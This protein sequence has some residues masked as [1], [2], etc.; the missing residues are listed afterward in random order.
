[1]PEPLR[2]AIMWHYGDRKRCCRNSPI[3]WASWWRDFFD[4]CAVTFGRRAS[5]TITRHV[6]SPLHHATAVGRSSVLAS[7]HRKNTVWKSPKLSRYATHAEHNP[8][9]SCRFVWVVTQLADEGRNTRLDGRR[10]TSPRA[11]RVFQLSRDRHVGLR[12]SFAGHEA[13]HCIIFSYDECRIHI[14]ISTGSAD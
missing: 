4:V 10:L 6:A 12:S 7:P 3:W 1:M 8:L 13:K 9:R 2:L 11:E 14:V 5:I